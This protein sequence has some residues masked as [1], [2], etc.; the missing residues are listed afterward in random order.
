MEG[1]DARSVLDLQAFEEHLLRVLPLDAA[2][3]RA[4]RRALGS[5][6]FMY[7]SLC[8]KID[9]EMLPSICVLL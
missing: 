9:V 5:D 4:H 6:F 8:I 7:E 1:E 3:R 2:A